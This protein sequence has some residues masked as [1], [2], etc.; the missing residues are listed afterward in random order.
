MRLVPALPPFDTPLLEALR[1]DSSFF[2]KDAP[3]VRK[4]DQIAACVSVPKSV[5][6]FKSKW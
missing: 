6:Q 2:S 5:T 4:S 1:R 3:I